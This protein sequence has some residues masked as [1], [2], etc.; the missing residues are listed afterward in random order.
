MKRKISFILLLYFFFNVL[1]CSRAAPTQ[2]QCD[3]SCYVDSVSDIKL[4]DK[5]VFDVIDS[6]IS[7][8]SDLMI[9]S[10]DSELITDTYDTY[11]DYDC[12]IWEEVFWTTVKDSPKEYCWDPP[13]SWC[14]YPGAAL[15]YACNESGELCCVFRDT[16]IPCGWKDIYVPSDSEEFTNAQNNPECVPIVEST[17]TTFLW[18]KE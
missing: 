10:D 18:C 17:N 12:E 3:N 7:E 5:F 6:D 15:T 16:C 9:D 1:G 2:D 11:T 8:I 14:I 4:N 13:E